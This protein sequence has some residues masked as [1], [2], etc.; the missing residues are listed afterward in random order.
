[1]S[2]AELCPDEESVTLSALLAQLAQRPEA[3]LSIDDLVG[4]FGA[5][6]FGATLFVFAIPN[7]L[8]L[9]PGSST[10]LGMPLL[11]L[12]PQLACGKSEPWLPGSIRRRIIARSALA[13]VYQRIGPWLTKVERL[14]TRRLAFLFGGPGDMLIGLICTALAAVLILPIPLGNLL[15]ATAIAILGLSLV[16]R[17][18]ALAVV[19][20]L[21]AAIS[22]GVLMLSG[23][24]V[25]AAVSRLLTWL[26]V[27]GI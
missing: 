22:F 26:G 27:L 18:G 15:P 12:A 16:H 24:V 8:P 21:T 14:T 17:D 19:G 11:L 25:M 1:M 23:Q 6:A 10:V 2:Q 13:T 7:L 20:Y 9:P 4:H 3:D 5:R